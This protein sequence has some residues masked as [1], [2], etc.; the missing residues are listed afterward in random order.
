MEIAR[1][2][3]RKVARDLEVK[4]KGREEAVEIIA[5]LKEASPVRT[6]KYRDAWELQDRLPH[7]G[8]PAWAAVNDDEKANMIEYGTGFDAEGTHS[9]WGRFT[10]TPEFGVAAQ[11][12]LKH[13]GTAP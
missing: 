5:E 12:A 1:E 4:V 9:P 11:V 8:M 13:G 2:I 3:K 6:G 7:L 10:D